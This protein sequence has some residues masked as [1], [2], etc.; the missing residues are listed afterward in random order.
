MLNLNK[1]GK[2]NLA[3]EFGLNKVM[4]GLG[5][6][7][8]RF[9]SQAEFDL[10][11]T[12]FVLQEDGSPYGKIVTRPTAN[13]GWVCFYNQPRLP[14]DVVVH[15][16]DNR[17]GGG[18]GDDE[19]ITIDFTKMPDEASRVV[20]VVTI[21]EAVARRQTFGM[22]DDAYVKIYDESGAELAQYDLDEKASTSASMMFVEFKKNGSGEWVM[23]AIGEGFSQGLAE[24][25]KLYKVP[26]F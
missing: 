11:A 13:D 8:K 15:S 3:K 21:H 10:D 12:A 22:V 26:G 25:C 1:G 7:T 19:Q 24:F 18:D 6:N 16:G 5:W 2:L 9:E 17:T 20:I 14:G 4:V 23:Q